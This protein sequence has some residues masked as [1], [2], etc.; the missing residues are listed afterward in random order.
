MFVLSCSDWVLL[1]RK[2][3]L[4]EP[5]YK[6]R[7]GLITLKTGRSSAWRAV[8]CASST[9]CSKYGVEDSLGL[10]GLSFLAGFTLAAPRSAISGSGQHKAATWIGT[11][12]RVIARQVPCLIVLFIFLF[13][14]VLITLIISNDHIGKQKTSSN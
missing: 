11:G 2:L 12:R 8:S 9:S 13:I 3:L 5:L 14:L 1:L 7:V 6:G 4:R 10:T